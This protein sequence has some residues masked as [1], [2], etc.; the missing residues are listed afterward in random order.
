MKAYSSTYKY[1][2]MNISDHQ[3]IQLYRIYILDYR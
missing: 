1:L 2:M 3:I